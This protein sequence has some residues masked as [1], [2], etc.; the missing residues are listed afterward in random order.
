M[1]KCTGTLMCSLCH[2][3]IG[4]HR[5]H[6]ADIRALKL[7]LL[8]LLEIAGESARLGLT[9]EVPTDLQKMLVEVVEECEAAEFM[10]V[11][12]TKAEENA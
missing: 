12:L 7:Q 1:N 2:K 6:D 4:E 10:I 3:E 8:D 5:L 9:M 11:S